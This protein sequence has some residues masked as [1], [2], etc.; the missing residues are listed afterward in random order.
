MLDDI[1]KNIEKAGFAEDDALAKAEKV[2]SAILKEMDDEETE[3]DMDT[4]MEYRAIMRNVD[5]DY[6]EPDE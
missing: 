1:K 4:L 6:D 2:Y 5:T 3:E